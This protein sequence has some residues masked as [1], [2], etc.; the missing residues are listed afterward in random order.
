MCAQPCICLNIA[1]TTFDINQD[2]KVSHNHNANKMR[3][4]RTVP[5]KR[6]AD[7]QEAA[8]VAQEDE[9]V[10]KQAKKK[11]AIRVKEGRARPIDWLAVILRIV[12]SERDLLDDDLEDSSLDV[13]DPDGLLEG[14]D[15]S[16]LSDLEKD[17]DIYLALEKSQ[18]NRNFWKVGALLAFLD[19]TDVGY[20]RR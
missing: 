1:R 13:V 10:L 12:D 20:T 2:E 9:F 17:I 16:Q 11:A 18:S 14:L 5:L 15:S 3:R 4:P 6:P 19:V 7:T 8:W